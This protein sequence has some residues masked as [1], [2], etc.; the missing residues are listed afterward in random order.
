M[1]DDKPPP[2]RLRCLRGGLDSSLSEC[3]S[4]GCSRPSAPD[5]NL[6]DSCQTVA[7]AMATVDR[8]K[9][10]LLMDELDLALEPITGLSPAL[11]GRLALIAAVCLHDGEQPAGD[12]DDLAL[13]LGHGL[14]DAALVAHKTPRSVT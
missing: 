3:R 12:A 10:A 11:R 7:D 6:C 5:G 9:L 4:A 1:P 2:E 14:L 13:A 8:E